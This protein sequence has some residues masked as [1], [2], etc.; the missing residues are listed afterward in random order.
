MSILSFCKRD[1]VLKEAGNGQRA[2][3]A[4]Y[5]GQSYVSRSENE[6]KSE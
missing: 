1:N 3:S 6:M 4:D 2:N 5:I